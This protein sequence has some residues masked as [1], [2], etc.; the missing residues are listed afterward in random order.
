MNRKPLTGSR[1]RRKNFQNL[2]IVDNSLNKASSIQSL[3]T[4]NYKKPSVQRKLDTMRLKKA[5][6]PKINTFLSQHKESV[7]K[8]KRSISR[9]FNK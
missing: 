1:A 6:K 2:S 4:Q 7:E 9:D 3:A 5:K 8:L